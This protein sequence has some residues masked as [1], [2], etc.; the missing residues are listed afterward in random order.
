[1]MAIRAPRCKCVRVPPRPAPSIALP[2]GPDRRPVSPDAA[3]DTM[4]RHDPARVVRP[5]HHAGAFMMG[6]RTGFRGVFIGFPP[7]RIVLA[8][9]ALLGGSSA[10]AGA[11]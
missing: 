9:L 1:M 6:R 8:W 4:G 3:R 11:Q 7:M 5:G 2:P 10:Q